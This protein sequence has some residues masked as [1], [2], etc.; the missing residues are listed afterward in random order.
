MVNVRRTLPSLSSLS[1]S[2]SRMSHRRR[3]CRAASSRLCEPA[4]THSNE[5]FFRVFRERK[6]GDP[7]E[8]NSRSGL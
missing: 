5:L 8:L 6:E 3:R 2:S 7:L 1:M 4:D